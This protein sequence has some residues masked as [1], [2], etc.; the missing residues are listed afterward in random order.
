MFLSFTWQTQ[1]LVKIPKTEVMVEHG[2]LTIGMVSS[3]CLRN[4]KGTEMKEVMG[5]F[6]VGVK[7]RHHQKR[8][9]G[10]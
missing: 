9:L 10:F 1:S 6:N 2:E 7:I 8:L 5:V 4:M 3:V